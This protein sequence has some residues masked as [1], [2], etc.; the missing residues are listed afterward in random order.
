MLTETVV[1]SCE[2]QTKKY[3]C[4]FFYLCFLNE[5]LEIGRDLIISSRTLRGCRAGSLWHIIAGAATLGKL[6]TNESAVM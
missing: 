3:I 1:L 2:F 5:L 4:N 6:L